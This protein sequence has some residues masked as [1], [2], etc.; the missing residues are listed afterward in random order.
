MTIATMKG[1]LLALRAAVGAAAL[2]ALPAHADLVTSPA[3]LPVTPFAFTLGFNAPAGS[4]LTSPVVLGRGVT[5][6]TS[7]APGSLG[8]APLGTWFLE[9]SALGG[10]NGRW[11]QGKTFAGVDG[12]FASDGSVVA[13]RFSFDK[14]VQG[15]G[16]FMNYDPTYTFGVSGSLPLPLYLAALDTAGNVLEDWEVPIL[17]PGGENEGAFYGIG[18]GSADIAAFVI[19]G[20]FAVVDDLQVAAVPEP[21]TWAMLLAGLA[22]LG[23]SARRSRGG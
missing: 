16:G 17:T 22:L 7:G 9:D 14:P 21:S 8:E 3:D 23:Y 20:P 18:R 13:M 6:S 1:L 4:N 2:A 11:S 12:D 15:V 10:G 19:S 5:F